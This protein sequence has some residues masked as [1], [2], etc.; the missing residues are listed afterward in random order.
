MVVN[1]SRS[2]IG[3]LRDNLYVTKQIH[4]RPNLFNHLCMVIQVG[5]LMVP[6]LLAQGLLFLYLVFYYGGYIPNSSTTDT[7]AT[8]NELACKDGIFFLL[9]QQNVGPSRHKCRFY[10]QP[11]FLTNWTLRSCSVIV[12]LNRLHGLSPKCRRQNCL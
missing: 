8:T 9:R 7:D 5:Q 10:V 4:S 2:N 6:L 1:C 3:Y 11:L 12:T